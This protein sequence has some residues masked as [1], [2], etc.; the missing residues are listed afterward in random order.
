MEKQTVLARLGV[1]YPQAKK[2]TLRDMVESRR[3][4]AKGAVVISAKQVVEADEKLEVVDA[5]TVGTGGGTT[6]LAEGLRLIHLDA[7]IA[8]VEKPAGL[9]TATDPSEKRPTAWRILTDYLKRGNHKNQ[10]HLIHRLDR[11][12]SGLLVFARNREAYTNL[13]KQFYDHTITRRYDVIVHRIPKKKTARLEHI[14]VEDERTGAVHIT[15]DARKGRVAILDYE[16]ADTSRAKNIAHLR[17]TLFTG[18]KH[19]IRVQLKA[20]G[21]AVCGDPVYGKAEEPPGRLA[22]HAGHLAFK[23][24]GTKKNASFDSPMPG[25]FGHMFRG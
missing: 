14:L 18:R 5:G 3:V 23:H 20:I 25:S 10:V 9:L 1:M 21:H 11:D 6:I 13:K 22:L 15:P 17:C 24:P 19:Q 8:V 4:R 16:L 12:A 7:H 2:N